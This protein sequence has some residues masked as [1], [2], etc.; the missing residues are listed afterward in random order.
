MPSKTGAA[1]RAGPSAATLDELLA[2]TR[3]AARAGAAV[4]ARWSRQRALLL[5][6]EK[7]APG[8]LVSQAD[9]ETEHAIRAVLREHRPR[10]GVIGEEGGAIAGSSG[11]VW[12]VDPI[13]G[14]TEYLYGRPNWAVSV[15]VVRERDGAVL[16]GVV[17]E[18]DAD[19]VTEARVGA[20]AWCNGRRVRCREQTDLARSLIEINLGAGGQRLLAGRLVDALVPRVRDVRDS[21]SAAA[22]LAAV[23]GGRL[24]GYWGPGLH[25]WDAAAGV[26]LV[27]EA[28]GTTGDLADAAPGVW[29]ASGDILAASPHLLR[30][31]KPLLREVYGDG[32]AAQSMLPTA[33][34][35]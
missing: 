4:A 3:E 16:A 34:D 30:Q 19:R 33:G 11:V 9:R 21:G 17:H 32:H 13:D 18:P 25:A 1:F 29:P 7:T 26:L 31:L 22:A 14:T 23:A 12:M 8:D 5:V 6:E 35:L 27:C 15:A 2:V 20:G 10:D 24:D 28:G